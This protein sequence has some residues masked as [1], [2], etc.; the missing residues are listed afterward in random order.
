MNKQQPN[1]Q[2]KTRRRQRQPARN[3]KRQSKTNGRRNQQRTNNYRHAPLS[4]CADEYLKTL[5]DPF[6]ATKPACIPDMH[7]VPSKKATYYQ[8]GTF[9]TDSG[10]FGSIVVNPFSVSKNG[11]SIIDTGTTYSVASLA[12]TDGTVAR[13][14]I[15]TYQNVTSPNGVLIQVLSQCPYG[16]Q[17]Y[18]DF[19]TGIQ[20]IGL[21]IQT[22]TVGCGLQIRYAGTK[23]NEGGTIYAT[24]RSDGESLN[25]MT[26]SQIATRHDTKIYPVDSKW[27]SIAYMPVQPDDYDY[28]KNG[29]TGTEGVSNIDTNVLSVIEQTRSNL[30][31]VV[32]SAAP[33]Q[34]FEFRVVYHVEMLGKSLDSIS[35]S[36]SD[37]VGMS[38]VRNVTASTLPAVAGNSV[39]QAAK[40]Y[41]GKQ[42]LEM[43]QNAGPTLLGMAGLAL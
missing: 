20:N 9:S 29:L 13:T 34:L 27:K 6:G 3:R 25:D 41:I 22:R 8:H 28:C 12:Y 38:A 11:M 5:T 26:I 1:Q 19:P 15:N 30:G 35:Q 36:H 39:Y 40:A 21:D 23:L 37:I 42:M 7:V 10:G 43:A 16:L 24:R 18:H 31:F 4:P 2:A 32:K 17:D 33:S 14:S